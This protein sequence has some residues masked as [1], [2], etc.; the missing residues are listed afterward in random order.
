MRKTAVLALLLLASVS[1]AQENRSV[2]FEGNATIREHRTFFL[3]NFPMEAVASGYEV[4]TNR[5]DAGYIFGFEVSRNM[6]QY[7][8]GTVEAAPPDEPQFIITISITRNEDN[9]ELASFGF[10]YSDIYA[11][12]EYTQYLFLKAAVNIPVPEYPDYEYSEYA[13][14]LPPDLTWMNKW[15][16][17]RLSLDFPIT[18]YALQPEGLYQEVAVYQGPFDRPT[19]IDAQENMVMALPGLTLGVEVQFL[20]WMS[21]EPMIQFGMEHVNDT[22]YFVMAAGLALRFPLK[23]VRQ[24]MLEPYANF[25]YTLPFFI[26]AVDIYEAMPAVGIGAGLQVGIRGGPLGIAFLDVGFTYYL[27]EAIKKNPHKDYLPDLIHYNR[28][29]IRLGIGYKFGFID[30]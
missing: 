17:V 6:I 15:L 18:F 10:P 20:D 21:A 28:Y 4:V 30:R 23:F 24:V 22:D 8:D 12:Y 27:G 26:P 16:Y 19:R 25:M 1:F 14:A 2:F 29:V 5:R 13:E 11:M 7:S 9:V 3:E